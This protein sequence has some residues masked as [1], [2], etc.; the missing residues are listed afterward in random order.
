[1]KLLHFIFRDQYTFRAFG[2]G[3]LAIVMFTLMP[4]VCRSTRVRSLSKMPGSKFAEM[5]L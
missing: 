4:W 2:A 3:L 5:L 1:M